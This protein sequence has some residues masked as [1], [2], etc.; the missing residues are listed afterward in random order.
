MKSMTGFGRA[1][2]HVGGI[3]ITAE[4]RSYNNRFLDV[5]VSVPQGLTS[6]E[7]AL[8]ALVAVRMSRGRVELQVRASGAMARPQVSTERARAAGDLLR[9]IARAAGASEDV[10][11]RDL[12][13][14]DRRLDL[15]VVETEPGG[16]DA[17][18]DL[19]A[20]VLEAAQC[21]LE[22]LDAEREREGSELAADLAFCLR[23]VEEAAGR[24][25]GL[26]AEW[27]ER[28]ER[29]VQT[30]MDR[31]LAADGAADRILPAI[32]LLLARSDVNEELK[33]LG[34]HLNGMCA[35]MA[36]AE[37]P[38]GKKLEFYCQ[39]L[40]RE[41]NT[42]GAK[43]SSA[44]VDSHVLTVKENVERMREQLRNVE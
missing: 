34:A 11:V 26:A 25:T 10:T 7:P 14:A 35:G 6:A 19:R 20:G 41:A 37:G 13:E 21:C 29:D 44:D 33:R 22:R 5:S 32:A 2:G 31:L 1:E 17:D 36:G 16:D 28:V 38:H 30:R 12:L 9:A 39:E 8:R 3:D 18:P 43:A 40:L 27:Q 15:G 24:L 42:I 4:V 23:K